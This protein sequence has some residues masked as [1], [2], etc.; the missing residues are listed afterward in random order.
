[1]EMAE[2]RETNEAEMAELRGAHEAEMAELRET[3]EAEM[4]ELRESHEARIAELRESGEALVAELRESADAK[5]R[6]IAELR[7]SAEAKEGRLAELEESAGA[8]RRTSEDLARQIE[9]LNAELESA[10][11]E[12]ELSRNSI[13]A[14]EKALQ[15]SDDKT[16]QLSR[17]LEEKESELAQLGTDLSSVRGQLEAR[18]SAMADSEKQIASLENALEAKLAAFAEERDVFEKQQAELDRE[19][20]AEI[21]KLKSELQYQQGKLNRYA[22]QREQS[23]GEIERLRSKVAKRGDA[24]RELQSQISSIMMQRASR[25]NEISLLKDKLR[26]VEAGLRNA[27][28]AD[29][30]TLSSQAPEPEESSLEE[31]IRRSLEN[32]TGGNGGTSLDELEHK[33]SH[34]EPGTQ[35][36]PALEPAPARSDEGDF[37]VYFDESSDGLPEKEMKKIDR[38]ARSFKQSGRKMELTVIGFAGPE[39]SANYTESLSARRADSV[40]QRL[41]ERGVPQNKISVQSAGQDRR[42]QDWKARRV[43]L[44]MAPRA[45]AESVN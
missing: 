38:C 19:Q 36:A 18:E 29:T 42:F 31:A 8:H 15:S 28:P 30:T 32:E 9:R 4:A 26:A 12:K 2:L 33:D 41:L 16:L 35:S 25:D 10:L 14:L 6:R 22:Q 11:H 39:G 24:V 23:L 34:H 37:V 43:E 5:D 27:R 17:R 21:E 3:N 40:R 7:K 13:A 45:V 44:V 20:S 1:A